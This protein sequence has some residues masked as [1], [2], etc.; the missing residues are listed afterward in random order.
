MVLDLVLHDLELRGRLQF[1]KSFKDH[2]TLVHDGVDFLEK[3]Y[4]EKYEYADP[5]VGDEY[6]VSW[7]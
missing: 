2:I 6:G 1:L 5:H 4:A 7:L 3:H